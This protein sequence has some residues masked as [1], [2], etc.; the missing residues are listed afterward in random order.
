[1]ATEERGDE[2]T[3]RRGRVRRER[4]RVAF[5]RTALLI[6]RRAKDFSL[7]PTKKKKK[8]RAVKCHDGADRGEAREPHKTFLKDGQGLIARSQK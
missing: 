7:P 1:M 8:A 5:A 4:H 2:P 3:L 6:T